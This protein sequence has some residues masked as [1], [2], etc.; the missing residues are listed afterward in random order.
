M[1]SNTTFGGTKVFLG[2]PD[3]I[4]LFTIC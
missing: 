3:V 4:G 1:S 2:D